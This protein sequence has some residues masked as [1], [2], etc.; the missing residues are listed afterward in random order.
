MTPALNYFI[1][2]RERLVDLEDKIKISLLTTASFY[3]SRI[4]VCNSGMRKEVRMVRCLAVSITCKISSSNKVYVDILNKNLWET[5]LAAPY[6]WKLT[7]KAFH[8]FS[9]L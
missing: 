7:F 9:Q 4:S 5:K 2:P 3:N 1:R 8:N 6:F